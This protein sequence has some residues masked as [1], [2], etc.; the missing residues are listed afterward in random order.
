MAV[1]DNH[2]ELNSACI[3]HKSMSG[4][5]VL[6]KSDIRCINNFFIIVSTTPDCK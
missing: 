1:H 6:L 3:G 4:C 2:G 5:H